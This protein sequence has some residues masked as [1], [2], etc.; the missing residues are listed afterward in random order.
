[1]AGQNT[2][3]LATDYNFIQ[4]KA[5]SVLGT[6]SGD[7]GYGQTVLSSPV[8]FQEKITAEQWNE[9]R[10]DILRAY[11]HRNGL[12]PT[13]PDS[14]FDSPLSNM[15]GHWLCN[16]TSGVSIIDSIDSTNHNATTYNTLWGV[17]PVRLFRSIFF[18]GTGTSYAKVTEK[19][20]TLEL[21]KVHGSSYTIECWIH[22]VA[23]GQHLT[24]GGMILSKSSDYQIARMPDGRIIIASDWNT[25]TDLNLVGGWIGAASSGALR[26]TAIAPLDASTH[27]AVVVNNMDLKIYI[28]GVESYNYSNLNR[29]ATI[30]SNEIYF[31]N[32]SSFSQGFNGWISDIRIWNIARTSG[33]IFNYYLNNTHTVVLGPVTNPP[34]PLITANKL[35][36]LD[37]PNTIDVNEAEGGITDA[38]RLQFATVAEE[39]RINRLATPPDGISSPVIPQAIKENLVPAQQKLTAW[40]G[41]LTQ[42]VTVTFSDASAARHFFNTGSRI[43]FSA[44]RLG[45]TASVKNQTWSDMLDEMG[46]LLF[47]AHSNPTLSVGFYEL[48]TTDQKIFEKKAPALSVYANNEYSI[49]ARANTL[50]TELIFTIHFNDVTG[51]V[52]SKDENV[53]GVLNSF[54]QVFRANGENV[55]VSKP[56]A[57]TTSFV[58]GSAIL[59]SY[60]VYPSKTLLT[61]GQSVTYY[62]EATN[63]GS[64]TLFWTIES[65]SILAT[66]F[67]PDLTQLSGS[68][69]IVDNNND[70]DLLVFTIDSDLVLTSDRTIALKIRTGSITGPIVAE[71]TVVT[72]L[73]PRYEVARVIKTLGV[74]TT[75]ARTG[76]EIYY[77]VTTQNFGTGTLYWRVQAGGTQT[78]ANTYG[79]ATS[80]SFNVV[81]DIG[82][83]MI[84]VPSNLLPGSDVNLVYDIR[85]GTSSGLIVAT[86]L[87][88]TLKLPTYDITSAPVTTALEDGNT[89]LQYNVTT[90]NYGNG[91]LYWSTDTNF[92]KF[93]DGKVNDSVTIV[94]GGG[95]IVRPIAANFN[96]PT[97]EDM[98]VKLRFSSD[99]GTVIDEAP[100]VTLLSPGFDISPNVSSVVRG[101]TV[102]FTI[103]TR[104]Y[105][106]GTIYWNNTGTTSSISN[107]FT[108]NVNS[109]SVAIVNGSATISMTVSNNVTISNSATIILKLNYGSLTGTEIATSSTVT[110][111]APSYTITPSLQIAYAKSVITYTVTTQNFGTGTLQWIASTGDTTTFSQAYGLTTTGSINIVNNQGAFTR[112]IPAIIESGSNIS[113]V[114]E[115]RFNLSTVATS[116]PVTLIKP[117]YQIT[118]VP[119]VSILEDGN[120][121]ISYT[122]T[123]TNF[124]S[125]T[126]Y[127]ETSTSLSKFSDSKTNSSIAIVNNSASFVRSIVA[128]FNDPTDESM[129][130]NL[131]GNSATGT[132]LATAPSVMLYSPGFTITPNV[133]SVIRGSIITYSITTK[134]YPNGTLHWRNSGTTSTTNGVFTDNLNSGIISVTN[135]TAT[136]TRTI[137]DSVNI[138]NNLTVIVSLRYGSS[139][140]P[141]VATAST[142]TLQGATY[143]LV[144]SPTTIYQNN[145]ATYTVTTTS[146]GSGSLYWS[147]A[148]SNAALFTDNE[149]SGTIPIANN[150]GTFTRVIKNNLLPDNNLSIDVN[151][152]YGSTAGTILD[153][154]STTLV[155]PGYTVTPDITSVI[156]G[157]TITYTVS[158]TNFGSGTLY[159]SIE[160]TVLASRFTD[161]NLTGSVNIVNNAG[162]ITRSIDSGLSI[163]SNE[164]IILRLR[165]VN[166]TGTIVATASTVTL[167]A[168][169]Y[170]ATTNLTTAYTKSAI[171]VTVATQNIPNGFTLYW[172]TASGTTTTFANTYGLSTSGSITINNNQGTF[173]FTIPNMLP[174]GANVSLVFDIRTNS[175]TGTIVTSSPTVTLVLPTFDIQPNKTTLTETGDTTVIYTVNVGSIGGGSGTVYWTARGTAS[176]ADFADQLMSGTLSVVNNSA[177]LTRTIAVD[178]IEE[179]SETIIMDLRINSITGTVV[180]TAPTVT[181]SAPVYSIVPNVTTAI[182]GTVVNYT[183][184][185]TN[186]GSGTLYWSTATGNTTTFADT[187][188]LPKTG[189]INIVNNAGSFTVTIPNELPNSASI[190]LI[191][192]LRRYSVTGDLV[193]TAS[194]VVLRF[195]TYSITP[196]KTSVIENGVDSVTF[197]VSLTNYGNG[198]LYW[199]T[200]GVPSNEFLDNKLDGSVTITNNTGTIIRAVEEDVNEAYAEAML[201]RLRLTSITGTIVASSSSVSLLSPMYTIT[202]NKTS[203]E[204]GSPVTFAVTTQNVATGAVLYWTTVQAGGT[205]IASD[206]SDNILTGSVTVNNGTASIIRTPVADNLSTDWYAVINGGRVASNT[207]GD[208]S[209]ADTYGIWR[210]P[211]YTP[212]TQTG[213]VSI[214]FPVTGNYTINFSSDDSSNWSIG[215]ITSNS[216]GFGYKSVT[217]AIPAGTYTLSWSVSNTGP[218]TTGPQNPGYFA[219]RILKPDGI[220]LTNSRLFATNISNEPGDKFALELR[221]SLPSGLLFATSASVDI[222]EPQIEVVTSITNLYT[223]WGPDSFG[224]AHAITFNWTTSTGRTGHVSNDMHISSVINQRGYD[225]SY[226]NSLIGKQ[227]S[228]PAV[229]SYLNAG[230]PEELRNGTYYWPGT[231]YQKVYR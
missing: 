25:G 167:S 134:N 105:N 38:I 165:T 212:G 214:N 42:T 224:G 198:T 138:T 196:N 204:E 211:I 89:L 40:N 86:A 137:T 229:S 10:T 61:R 17:M 230:S 90:T 48:T 76:S 188:G 194:T 220:E 32:N 186:F 217:A 155:R 12:G 93:E 23:A 201:L 116:S 35:S 19:N 209:F 123:T 183:V 59:T 191:Y 6:G 202:P 151:L 148:S 46:T 44:E 166:A 83:F 119:I 30:G 207:T 189:T 73:S 96:D 205:I 103:S 181:I 126:L 153:T 9:L 63:F 147:T 77:T 24:Y 3:I 18:K 34:I 131:R 113:L 199:T 107:L 225:G 60:S 156:T 50:K 222:T 175:N 129:T 7:T 109:G 168:P 187:Y 179:S 140:G 45:G 62:V 177:T 69:N 173:T 114:Y 160:G 136:L 121:S 200:E 178:S 70:D 54:V 31:G 84:G 145:T 132:V 4:A 92:A 87:P 67:D 172:T 197:T 82:T 228:D 159:W 169:L 117:T 112:S 43:E 71:S 49:Y 152:R 125:D 143:D 219:M 231:S 216:V 74:T 94:N 56:P 64:G 58:G 14:I 5:S 8:V 88:A 170:Q 102:T 161:N 180:A 195:P 16:Q 182:R 95:T 72:V 85:I 51:I 122:I 174:A 108:N 184:T 192:E 100:A 218:M 164:T 127:W 157:G 79:M 99:T 47:S 66:N 21:T 101:S 206:F 80:G 210:G 111:L 22:P 226:A 1:M 27:V 110:V 104:N 223:S 163:A 185:T 146:F 130:F 91:T 203:V 221:K 2:Q 75:T 28:N 227:Y 33:Q 13:P 150:S 36:I 97:D 41:D 115:L 106:T 162:T 190:N 128:N 149:S 171:I 213:T 29:A 193:A 11:W 154:A 65:G 141:T 176:S 118:S 120:N 55:S 78:F 98:I 20:D 26:S 81:S 133:T 53:D 124:G 208:G 158:L 139:S 215:T 39:N 57:T 68:V 144:V 37:D 142:V 52:N 135:G 15:V